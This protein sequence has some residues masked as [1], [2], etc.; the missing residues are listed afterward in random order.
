MS[1]H[2][3]CAEKSSFFQWKKKENPP[4]IE[5]S[6]KNMCYTPLSRA[7][8]ETEKFNILIVRISQK[9]N[10]LNVN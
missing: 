1:V 8:S 9:G 7:Y 4:I 2:S 5:N 6:K 3:F 10:K